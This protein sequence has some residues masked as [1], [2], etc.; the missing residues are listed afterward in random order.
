MPM[1]NRSRFFI[2]LT[3]IFLIFVAWKFLLSDSIWNKDSTAKDLNA[4]FQ[5]PGYRK[6]ELVEQRIEMPFLD[7]QSFRSTN[8]NI[9]GDVVVENDRF[10]ALTSD[11][12]HQAGLIF[13][14]NQLNAESFE[15]E[16]TFHIYGS[17]SLKA[18]GMALWLTEAPLPMGDLFG[19]RSDFVGLGIFIDTFR[20]GPTGQ[21]PY[22]TAQV[23]RGSTFYNKNDDGMS[24]QL[25]GCTAKSLLN[26]VSGKTT[27][28]LVYLKSG[29]LSVEFNYDPDNTVSWHKCFT[30]YNVQLPQKKYLGVSAETGQ[31]S[32]S[33]EVLGNRV[34]ALYLPDQD[35]FIDSFDQYF[36]QKTS[37]EQELPEKQYTTEYSRKNRLRR[38]KSV[39][40][41][42]LAEERVKKRGR[43][44]RLEKYGDPDATFVRRWWA[45]FVKS[46]KIIIGLIM[47]VLIIWVSR[48]VIKTRNQNRRS[49][50][51]GLLD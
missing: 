14:K 26:P 40:R 12:P 44:R 22:V 28:K 23:G 7:R 6:V 3:F 29:Y 13:N 21:F 46:T 38:R 27:I 35:K 1:S 20:N 39:Q 4:L 15:L 50:S 47:L 5:G 51:T 25:A 34:H 19:A 18:D 8:W 42:K 10:V 30:V 41:L 24:T 32:E 9:A 2:G 11:K 37:Y 45:M 36:D 31:I 17:R 49:R 43:E 16:L 33:V 48:L